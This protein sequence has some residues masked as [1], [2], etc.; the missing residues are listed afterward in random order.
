MDVGIQ[1]K[2]TM[3]R[4]D[5]ELIERLKEMAQRENRSLNN[6]VECVC[7]S[8]LRIMNLTKS[9]RPQW[10]KPAAENSGMCLLLIH[11]RWKLCL[12]L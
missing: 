12:N 9:R 4:L 1:K 3:F 7:C 10:K 6:F 11:H 8:M 5:V 2:T